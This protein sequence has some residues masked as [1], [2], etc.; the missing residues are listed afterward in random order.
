[1]SRDLIYEKLNLIKNVSGHLSLN[2]E[3]YHMC[4]KCK[5]HKVCNGLLPDRWFEVRGKYLCIPCERTFGKLLKVQS[6]E[7]FLNKNHG[8]GELKFSE[9]IHCL[10]C[11]EK[12]EGVTYPNC[13]H[14]L[15]LQCFDNNWYC[16]NKIPEPKFP[17]SKEIEDRYIDN[18]TNKCWE[19]YPLIY[20]YERQLELIEKLKDE[21]FEK[22]QPFRKCPICNV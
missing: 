1:M 4:V 11:K 14:Y 10:Q 19:K 15:C 2:N 22:Y 13:E 20:A 18:P 3:E 8:N 21:L 6:P 9:N 5:N 7:T 12:G 16:Y 17:Y